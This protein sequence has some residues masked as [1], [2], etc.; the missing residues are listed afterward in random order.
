[1]QWKTING[2]P[3]YEVSSTGL[4]KSVRYN[5]L[6]KG[7]K[8]DSGYE[9]VNLIHNRIKKTTAI[10]KLVMEHFGPEKPSEQMIIDHKD[11]N[12]INNHIDNLEWVT[13]QE[14]TIRGYKNNDK[15]ELVLQLKKE[16][17][18]VKEICSIVGLG[19]DAVRQTLIK[20]GF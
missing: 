14:N 17:K 18:T 7:S 6:L 16:N 11:G 2:Y 3:N 8:N 9:Y 19:S 4:V 1:M 20:A 15:K 13:I 10:H 12:K 5:R